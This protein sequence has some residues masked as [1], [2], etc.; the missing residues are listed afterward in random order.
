MN[1]LLRHQARS[2]RA[3][4][5]SGQLRGAALRERILA[6]PA[7]ERDVWLDELLGLPEAPPDGPEL[8][9]GGV[10]YLPAGVDEIL[11]MVRE[12]PLGPGDRLVDFGA[13]IGRV[14]MLAHLLSGAAACGIEVQQ[15]LVRCARACC[16][17][18]GLAGIELI[19]ANAADVQPDGSVF[20]FYAPFGGETLRRVLG[21]LRQLA[22]RHPIV[23]CAVGLEL[24]GERWLRK[25][26]S[27][28]PSL[29]IYDSTPPQPAG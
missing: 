28:G 20:F 19:H 9:P 16:A 18:L 13:G 25:R 22:G 2:A 27:T 15:P 11:E 10:P 6:V 4:L 29:S 8:P 24:P 12:V 3:E 26:Q 17:A 1:Y 7:L 14:V 23:I 21:H 5:M